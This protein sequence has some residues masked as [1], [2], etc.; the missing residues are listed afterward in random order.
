MVPSNTLAF[1][2]GNFDQGS[3]NIYNLIDPTNVHTNSSDDEDVVPGFRGVAK[4]NQNRN[5][6]RSAVKMANVHGHLNTYITEYN[7]IIARD[8][9]SAMQS[10]EAARAA[11]A[12]APKLEGANKCS[13][14][15]VDPCTC[16]P[17]RKK[18]PKIKSRN[19]DRAARKRELL[20]SVGVI[21]QAFYDKSIAEGLMT[22]LSNGK[23]ESIE[24]ESMI[25]SVDDGGIFHYDDNPD[26]DNEW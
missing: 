22:A 21:A 10:A 8:E 16:D 7:D 15:G 17:S 19:K 24:E 18:K 1:S 26:F 25:D 20:D 5:S 4:F 2:Q 13:E 14:C 9:Q 6:G 3:G 12:D 23:L 11:A